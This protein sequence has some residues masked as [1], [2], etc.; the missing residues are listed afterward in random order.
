[1]FVFLFFFH[2]NYLIKFV[3]PLNIYKHA[4][5]HD[6]TLN[7]ENFESISAVWT[8]VILEWIKPMVSETFSSRTPIPVK[9]NIMYL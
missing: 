5:C 1:M 8:Y 9:I 2:K 3:H 4:K 6:L 7:G